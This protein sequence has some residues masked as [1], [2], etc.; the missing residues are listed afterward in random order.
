MNTPNVPTGFDF[1]KLSESELRDLRSAI[2]AHLKSLQSE[3]REEATKRV[4]AL[5]KDFDL[6]PEEIFKFAKQRSKGGST[7]KVAPKYRDPASGATWTGRGKAPAWIAGQ[8]R[9]AF[10]IQPSLS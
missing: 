1:A 8:D 3:A 2:D 5:V 9:G 6:Q 10:A 4:Q 7:G